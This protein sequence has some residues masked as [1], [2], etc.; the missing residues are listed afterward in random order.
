MI[1]K[2]F[3]PTKFPFHIKQTI[4][5]ELIKEQGQIIRLNELAFALGLHWFTA[6]K[7]LDELIGQGLVINIYNGFRLAHQPPDQS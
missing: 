7:A 3:A 5:S 4:H 2:D 6:K 1:I